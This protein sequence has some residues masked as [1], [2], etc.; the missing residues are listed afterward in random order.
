MATLLSLIEK[1][2]YF[3]VFVVNFLEL[4]ALPVSGELTMSYAGFLAF[5]GKMNYLLAIL[6]ATTGSI[7]GITITYWIG[8]RFGSMLIQKYGK[9]VHFGPE[10]YTKTAK[11]FDRYG[12]RLLIFSYF[13]P[14]VRHFTG[15]FS[16]ISRLPFRIFAIYAYIGAFL[17][18][19][20]FVT[21]GKILGPQWDKFHQSASKY[22]GI[23]IIGLVIFIAIMFIYRRYRAQIKLFFYR[24]MSVLYSY[25]RTLRGLNFF[26][27]IL[28]ISLLSLFIFLF[29][30][31]ENY[32][33]REF[34]EFNEVTTYVIFAIF[35]EDWL[36]VMRGF[37]LLQ[38]PFVLLL[39]T[40]GACVF[41]FVNTQNP[42]LE[43]LFTITTIFG[44][45]LY[46]EILTKVFHYLQ[47][48]HSSL[49]QFEFPNEQSLMTIIV[50]G[51]FIFM[52]V[53]HVKNKWKIS[54]PLAGLFL[55]LLMGI[56]NVY[57]SIRLP[58]DV[59]A[60][61]VY[62]AAWLLLNLLVLELVRLE[63]KHLFKIQSKP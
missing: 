39:F 10:K 8:N 42:W 16:G 34:G 49:L 23:A 35:N 4:I 41:I 26:I 48:S 44:G 13:I 40:L 21:L 58:S 7:S 43:V 46:Q 33:H 61:F 29:G 15:Y 51:F 36:E 55:L 62:G 20:T 14:G 50:Y 6:A 9:Y 2:S 53:S 18:G 57:L 38:S 5:Q 31:G 37:L 19:L 32:L 47:P 52:L 22:L 3:L 12:N 11:W 56:A 1:Y 63:Q 54:A 59:V 45:I 60:G 24:K 28:S 17:W 27:F 25:F 30:L